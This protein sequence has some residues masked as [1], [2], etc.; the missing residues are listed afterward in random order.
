M[1]PC[2]AAGRAAERGQPSTLA[3]AQARQDLERMMERDARESGGD[4]PTSSTPQTVEEILG[5]SDP[6]CALP[7]AP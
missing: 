7:V 1:R 4:Q 2:C 3:S 6:L 5:I